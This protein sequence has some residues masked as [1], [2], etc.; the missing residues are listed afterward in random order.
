[1]CGQASRWFDHTA[2]TTTVDLKSCFLIFKQLIVPS[3]F[4]KY[5]TQQASWASNNVIAQTG[6]EWIHG[7]HCTWSIRIV[8]GTLLFFLIRQVA[9]YSYTNQA[10]ISIQHASDISGL[11]RGEYLPI[12]FSWAQ[13]IWEC[14]LTPRAV[15]RIGNWSKCWHRL[16]CNTNPKFRV[17]FNTKCHERQLERAI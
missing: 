7:Q 5:R 4:S 3:M 1:M 17:R 11:S 12:W 13:V 14:F 16:K 8:V 15:Y 6:H 9:S 10:L 2:C